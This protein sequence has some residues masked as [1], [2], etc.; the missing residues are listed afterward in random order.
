MK[1]K[2]ITRGES[3]TPHSEVIQVIKTTFLRGIGTEDDMYRQVTA[4][5]DLDGNLLAERD[6]HPSDCLTDY[7][8]LLDEN[9]RLTNMVRALMENRPK[10]EAANGQEN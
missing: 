6:D 1:T 3:R 7:R 5:H 4:Y 2:K 8:T 9:E 10:Q